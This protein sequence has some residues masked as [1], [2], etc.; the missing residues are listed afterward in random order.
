[1]AILNFLTGAEPKELSALLELFLLPL[2]GCF[3]CKSATLNDENISKRLH[4]AGHNCETWW[5]SQL[6][7]Q[8]GEFWMGTINQ[9]GLMEQPLRRRIGYINAIDDLIKHLG[10][11]LTIYLP[12][13]VSLLLKILK[14]SALEKVE[15]EGSKDVRIRCI[16]LLSI[17]FQAFPDSISYNFVWA[18]LS[19]AT[20]HLLTNIAKEA[21]ADRPPAL[22]DLC[23]S[24]SESSTLMANLHASKESAC[25]YGSKLLGAC[26]ATLSA[27]TC[28]EPSR[29]AILG[30]IENVLDSEESLSHEILGPHVEIVLSGLETTLKCCT[31]RSSLGRRPLGR[32]NNTR[33]EP[34]RESAARALLILEK[35]TIETRDIKIALQ[36]TRTLLPLLKVPKRKLQEKHRKVDEELICRSLKAITAIWRKLAGDCSEIKETVS[37]QFN[38]FPLLVA[39]LVAILSSTDARNALCESFLALSAFNKGLME[40]GLILNGMN[41]M[42]KSTLDEPNYDVRLD[43][44]TSLDPSVWASLGNDMAVVIGSQCCLDVRNESDLSLRHAAARAIENLF[45]AAVADKTSQ[46]VTMIRRHMMPEFRLYLTSPVIAVRQELLEL[47]RKVSLILPENFPELLP[48]TN[49]D[50]EIDFWLN[51]AHVQLHRRARHV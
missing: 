23:N 2:S 38:G 3:E 35:L 45:E 48:L 9:N 13:V 21:N 28:A 51:V 46:L 19:E 22:L 30:I 32:N 18:P 7:K 33:L 34:S 41:A 5:G 25:N 43:S 31:N 37:E 1:M 50:E 16:R 44:F 11:K 10:H 6:G 15:E 24:V 14:I 39:P 8:D 49:S 20:D 27:S 40:G 17:I 29:S 4:L 36:L 47:I 42:S 26:V 12:E